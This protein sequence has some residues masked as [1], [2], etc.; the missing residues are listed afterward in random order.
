MTHR[1][2]AVKE[3]SK[4]TNLSWEELLFEAFEFL[5]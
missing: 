1:M 3:A 2:A 5:L 4:R